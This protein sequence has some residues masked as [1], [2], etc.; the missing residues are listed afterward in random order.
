MAVFFI[1]MSLIGLELVA[2]DDDLRGVNHHTPGAVDEARVG[3]TQAVLLAEDGEAV[4]ANLFQLHGF[5]FLDTARQRFGCWWRRGMFVFR[6][7]VAGGGIRLPRWRPCGYRRR[8][9]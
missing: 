5:G 6:V 1:L 7:M 3:I 8:L 2:R 9:G 4:V